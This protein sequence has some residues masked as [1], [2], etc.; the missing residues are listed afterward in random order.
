[1]PSFTIKKRGFR[2]LL[3]FQKGTNHHHFLGALKKRDGLGMGFQT[4]STITSEKCRL[5]RKKK[6]F[7]EDENWLTVKKI[8]D[9]IAMELERCSLNEI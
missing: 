4:K 9:N 2:V 6:N 7:S 8:E 5:E 1:M 3:N